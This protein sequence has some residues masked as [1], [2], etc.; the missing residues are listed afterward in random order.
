MSLTPNDIQ[1]H[2]ARPAGESQLG[3]RVNS[4]LRNSQRR[5]PN[6][7]TPNAQRPIPNS[8]LPTWSCPGFVDSATLG[9]VRGVDDGKATI[10]TRVSR[11]VP[12]GDGAVSAQ[13]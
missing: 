1:R 2:D 10:P 3:S 11:G 5:I 8:Q 4:Q 7:Q 6:F 13:W 12:A 9:R